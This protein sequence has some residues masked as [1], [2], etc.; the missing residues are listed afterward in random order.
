MPS[1]SDDET[2]SE[3]TMTKK[4]PDL[5]PV[6]AFLGGHAAEIQAR[7]EVLEKDRFAS[8]FW[9]KDPD[10]W[11]SDPDNRKSIANSMGWID[12]PDKISLHAPA[13][14][15]FARDLRICR[16]KHV[17]HM[18]MGGSSLAPLAFRE[19]FES[20]AEGLALTVLDSTSPSTVLEIERRLPMAETFFI[21]ASK[22]GGTVESRSFGEYFYARM[23]AVKGEGAG[24]H[25]AVVTDPGSVLVKLAEERNYRGTFLN[26]GDIGGRYSALSFFGLVPAALMGLD[27]EEILARSLSM[28]EA[29]GPDVP[30]KKNPG[31]TLGVVMGEMALRGRNK[32][33]LIAP[34][35]LST[36]G[37]WLEQ[38]V[39]ESTGKEGKGIVP[40]VGEPLGDPAVYDDDRLFVVL[41]LEG[42][43]DGFLE[44]RIDA[45]RKAGHPVI[46]VP[47]ADRLDLG[48]EFFRWEIATA[49]AG[50]I[51]G[52]NP[53][54]QPNVQES[55][56]ITKRFLEQVRDEGC[57]VEGKIELGDGPLQFYG[58]APGAASAGQALSRFLKGA[59]SGDYL[60]FLAYLPEASGVEPGLR[61]LRG[62]VRDRLKLA[63]T[64][65]FGP[66][67]LHSTGQLHKG[68]PNTGLFLLITCDDPEDVPVPGQPYTFG[69]LKRAQAL[70]DFEAL[71]KHG[72]R[73]L[74]VHIAGNPVKGL[75]AL[76]KA[77]REAL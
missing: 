73:V 68:G 60:A 50:A 63:T 33:T 75:A 10:L 53:F 1:G 29:C 21:E 2:M 9:R 17:V 30:V 7:I 11:K 24:I 25:F 34:E 64:L 12:L 5:Y 49:T 41:C 22:S 26:F 43:V 45:L 71:A 58:T 69:V 19:I 28:M 44:S 14:A 15:E 74:R 61:N 20:G 76:E 42:E 70:G 72:R 39:A 66:R 65:G 6:N 77:F 31:M 54:D 47:M 27:V 18:G 67:Y 57:L 37:L 51:L 3:E 56:D 48:R 38:L 23:R 62:L 16:F 32:L 8:R 36:L 55:K 52:I 35:S 46:V 59:R 40:V 13:L 4:V